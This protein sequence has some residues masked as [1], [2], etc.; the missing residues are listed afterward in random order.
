MRFHFRNATLGLRRMGAPS[1]SAAPRSL[2]GG[3]IFEAKA[4][5]DHHQGP[6][7]RNGGAEIKIGESVGLG[8][9]LLCPG[10]ISIRQDKKGRL[11]R[12]GRGRSGELSDRH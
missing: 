2:P 8:I 10:A 9:V 7:Q 12:S 11:L 5:R 4:H 6:W 3:T 1:P